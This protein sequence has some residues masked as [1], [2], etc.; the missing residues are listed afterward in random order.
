MTVDMA[1]APVPPS[2]GDVADAGEL[3]GSGCGDDPAREQAKQDL[4]FDELFLLDAPLAL[5]ALY[6][7]VAAL[8]F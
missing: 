8:R 5:L 6:G 7:S 3:R 1:P 2:L 4:L